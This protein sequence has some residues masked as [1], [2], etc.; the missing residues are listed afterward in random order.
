[1]DRPPE[2]AN[3]EEIARFLEEDFW[4]QAATGVEETVKEQSDKAPDNSSEGAKNE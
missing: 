4:E 3:A 1:M 2:D